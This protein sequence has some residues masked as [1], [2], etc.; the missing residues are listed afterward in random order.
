[1]SEEETPDESDDTAVELAMRLRAA[2]ARLARALRQQSES[3][4]TP[5]QQII[6]ATV[7]DH[8]PM[9]AGD[10]AAREQVSPPTISRA[11][12]QLESDGLLLRATDETDRR[13]TRVSIT[14]DGT[15]QLV[16]ARTR[17]NAWLALR[18][19]DLDAQ[20]RA[21]LAGAIDVLERLA[22]RPI[23]DA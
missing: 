15:T 9:A 13:V 4:L 23:P 22:E 10:L 6:L 2:I 7:H 1:M 20:D 17:R 16:R 5:S 21:R 12:A 8:G 18:L 19:R 11:L 3:G 14:S